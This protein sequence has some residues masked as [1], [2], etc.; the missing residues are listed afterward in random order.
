MKV[1]IEG[2]EKELVGL[3][4]RHINELMDLQ[5]AIQGG[6]FQMG[7]ALG[8]ALGSVTCPHS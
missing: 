1:N 6:S 3:K 8:F 7:F 4:G 5:V 2:K